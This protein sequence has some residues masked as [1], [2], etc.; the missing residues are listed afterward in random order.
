M[1]FLDALYGE[2]YADYYAAVADYDRAQF[3]LYRA[4]GHSAPCEA[5]RER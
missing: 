4:L 3:R 5:S 1:G 2:A